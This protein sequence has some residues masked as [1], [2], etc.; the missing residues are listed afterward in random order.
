MKMLSSVPLLLLAVLLVGCG[1]SD[2]G[3]R[4]VADRGAPR[5]DGHTYVVTGI[6]QAGRPRRVVRGSELRLAFE[7]RQL[8]LTGGCNTMSGAYA[9]EGSRLTVEGLSMTEMGCE[10]PLLDQDSWLAGL[11]E[12][13]VQLTTGHDAA[14]IAGDVVLALADREAVHPDRPL[15]GTRWVLDGIVDGSTASSVPEGT[16]ARLE[17]RGR[18]ARVLD[19]CDDVAATGTV[20]GSTITWGPGRGTLDACTPNAAS[21]G[22][23]VGDTATY[24]ITEDVLRITDGDRGLTFRA[25]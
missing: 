13:P 7:G 16:S 3:K 8:R 12:K 24:V 25:R 1:S 9:L 18:W 11:F 23:D 20:S 17:V 15:A 6:T 2:D 19:G 5:V 10:Q 22:L 4:L 21:L 14:L